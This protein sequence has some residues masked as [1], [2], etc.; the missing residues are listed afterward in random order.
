M[1]VNAEP[2]GTYLRRERELRRVSLHDISVATKIQLR[3][4]EALEEDQYD[5]LPP[6]PFVVGFLRAYAQYLLL[7]PEEIVAAFH[8][9]RSPVEPLIDKAPPV[10]AYRVEPPA[11]PQRV[12]RSGRTVWWLLGGAG[13]VL[14][15]LGLAVVRYVPLDTG[16]GPLG[17][18][19]GVTAAA[20]PGFPK[21]AAAPPA[22]GPAPPVVSPERSTPV[23]PGA[24]ASAGESR[25]A[26]PGGTAAE[27]VLPPAP[28]ASPVTE[29]PPDQPAAAGEVPEPLVLEAAAAEDT[30]L[31]IEI[32]G[33]KRQ[34]MLLASGRSGRWEAKERIVMTIGNVRGIRLTLNGKTVQ[35]PPTRGNVARDFL[36]SRAVLH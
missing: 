33:G 35:L 11:R 16:N 22:V 18:P 32:D 26:L 13:V 1:P 27:A 10:L 5:R 15:G 6:T 3:F 23:V 17:Q 29:R 25:P 31:R 30:W 28:A 8:A 14:V 24:V 7:A 19:A 4:L 12:S 9:R 21:P 20:G 34:E 2:L 36:V